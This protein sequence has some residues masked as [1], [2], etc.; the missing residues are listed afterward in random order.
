MADNK[1]AVMV[2]MGANNVPGE[3][4]LAGP[5]RSDINEMTEA[6]KGAIDGAGPDKSLDVLVQVHRRSGAERLHFR[7]Q[8]KINRSN[9]PV[10]ERNTGDGSVW[11]FLLDWARRE[12]PQATHHLLVLWGHAYRLA[13]GRDGRD[14]MDFPELAHALGN[15]KNKS[16]KDIDVVG[17]DA[18]GMSIIDG[19]YQL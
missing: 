9:V 11:D 19:A 6:M 12:A 14:A 7:E 17:F 8:G 5:S 10:T 3:T 2:F 4:D 13:F 18:C 15:D 1:W 16:G